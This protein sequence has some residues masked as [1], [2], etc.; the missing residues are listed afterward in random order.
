MSQHIYEGDNAKVVLGYDRPLD[1]VFCT[2]ERGG[3]V[4]YSNLSDKNAGTEQQ[5]VRYYRSALDRLGVTVPEEMF[6]AVES[7]QRNRVGNRVVHHSGETPEKKFQ[8]IAQ[9]IVA[10]KGWRKLLAGEYSEELRALDEI[11]KHYG[12]ENINTGGNVHVAVVPLGPHDCMGITAE[13]VCHYVNSKATCVE[14]IFWEPENDPSEGCVSLVETKCAC[15]A[16]M[17]DGVCSDAACR[18]NVRE[19]SS[20]KVWDPR[21]EFDVLTATID[22]GTVWIDY[23]NPRH[24]IVTR[25][26]ES[27]RDVVARERRHENN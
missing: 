5:D 25:P 4:I 2:V 11:A 16:V 3:E 6:A 15:S 7:D 17:V 23:G 9:E 14:D 10:N 21:M 22:G 18:F 20:N 27:P 24:I 8:R 26:G 1:Y 12:G 13:V 19:S